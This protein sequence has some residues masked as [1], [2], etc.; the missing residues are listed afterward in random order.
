MG[1]ESA[2]PY[3]VTGPAVAPAGATVTAG[4]TKPKRL[5]SAA[6]AFTG[7]FVILAVLTPL[8]F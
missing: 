1:P 3:D 5:A 6:S 7:T 2:S 4:L 8:L